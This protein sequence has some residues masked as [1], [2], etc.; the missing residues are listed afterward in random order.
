MARPFVTMLTVYEPNQGL[1]ELVHMRPDR[2]YL[3][4][5]W[6]LFIKDTLGPANLSTV[7]SLSTLQRL[8]MYVLAL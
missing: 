8:K 7:E 2:R 1:S 5:Q 6:N 4:V 3:K